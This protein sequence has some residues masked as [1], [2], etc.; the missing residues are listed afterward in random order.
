MN[1]SSPWNV[2]REDAYLRRRQLAFNI[3]VLETC[4]TG[5]FKVAY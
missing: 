1:L 5:A 3:F 4:R 2:L